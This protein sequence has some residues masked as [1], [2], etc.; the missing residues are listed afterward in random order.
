[1]A[2]RKTFSI[3]LSDDLSSGVLQ[4]PLGVS[5]EVRTLGEWVEHLREVQRSANEMLST[6]QL[7]SFAA[8][9]VMRDIGKRGVPSLILTADGQV[10]LQVSYD[11]QNSPKRVE[12]VARNS[13]SSQLPKLDTLRERAD[14]MGVDISHLGRQ[15]RAIFNLLESR[16][17]ES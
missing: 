16:S 8:A 17:S 2:K 3:P 6:N 5:G 10:H 13:R 1:M 7:T 4:L 14:R 12:A 11:E 15:R 9:Q